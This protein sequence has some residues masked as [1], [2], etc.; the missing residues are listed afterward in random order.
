MSLLTTATVRIEGDNSGLKASLSESAAAMQRVGGQMQ[1]I[2]RRMSV[3]LT[4]PLAAVGAA[5]VKMASDAE[6][7]ANKFDVVMGSAAGRVR[8]QL[9]DL[10]RTIPLTTSQLESMSAGIQDLLVPMG[11]VRER[12]ADMSANMVQLAGDLGSFNNVDPSRVLEAMKS[13]LA[14]ASEPMRRYGVDTRVARL[15]SIAL[16]DG[17]IEAGEQLNQTAMAQAVMT[18]ITEDSADAMGDAAR[19]VDSTANMM[20]FLSRD[21]RQLGENIGATLIPAVRPLLGLLI[22]VTGALSSMS[23]AM[24]KITVA[25]AALAAAAGPLLLAVGTLVKA[26]P[27]LKVGFAALTGPIGL[28]VAAVASLTA[29][30]VA[31]V[32]N[33]DVISYE[34]GRMVDGIWD[35][36]VTRFNAIVDSVKGKIDDVTGWFKGMYEKVVG[37][38]YVPDMIDGIR[39]EF[40]RLDEVMV[41][42]AEEATGKVNESFAQ[43]EQYTSRAL[44]TISSNVDGLLGSLADLGAA[45]A[46]GGAIGLGMAAFDMLAGAVGGL[47]S[48]EEEEARRQA[49]RENTEALREASDRI[50]E[51]GS[52]VVGANADLFETFDQAIKQLEKSFRLLGSDA[53]FAAQRGGAVERAMEF[54]G[55]DPSAINMEVFQDLAERIQEVMNAALEEVQRSVVA[56]FAARAQELA[57][58]DLVAAQMRRVA[59]AQAEIAELEALAD[60]GL[61]TAQQL[62]E[63]SAIIEG[64]LQDALVDAARAAQ[65]AAEEFRTNLIARGLRAVGRGSEAQRV[66]LQFQ[67]SEELRKAIADGMSPRQLELLRGI[68]GI[69]RESFE[70]Q[71]ALQQQTAAIEESANQQIAVLEEQKRSAEKQLA[72]AR[73]NLQAQQQVVGNLRRV[74]TSLDDFRSS[75]LLSEFSPL[76]PARQLEEARRQFQALAGRAAAGDVAAGQALPE[77]GRTL[78]EASREFFASGAGFV[79]DFETVRGVL[80]QV[81]SNFRQQLSTEERSLRQLEVQTQTLADHIAAIDTMTEAIRQE[82]NRQIE[83]I[84]AAHQR[85]M[86]R[87][88][89]ILQQLIDAQGPGFDLPR[90]DPPGTGRVPPPP[91]IDTGTLPLDTGASVAM[92]MGEVVQRLERLEAAT[93]QQTSVVRRELEGAKL[94]PR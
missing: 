66:A 88:N 54:F 42:P 14:G 65:R 22:D 27:V 34:V 67:Q 81:G 77:A 45:F 72:V 26:L 37:G 31:L 15:E 29:A 91:P 10:T 60:K 46:S 13:A 76:S 3:A 62:A 4:V 23:P 16:R 20:R 75:L 5:S 56:D 84:R 90:S 53:E 50:A 35:A 8:Q 18:A 47:F 11:I 44:R 85:E 80:A 41:R 55:L 73:E 48:N 25:V 24:Q 87:L 64:E 43:M 71:M 12:A 58:N 30:G 59:A 70:L 6:E 17:L 38:S 68:Q 36:L 89:Q 33:W 28:S 2:G 51:L 32:D 83:A 1:N 69:E 19:T 79:E 94:A 57:G 92:G 52:Q 21:V 63:F 86:D 61:I 74:I 49:L 9:Q 40:L 78:L 82:A 7:A 39:G 93:R